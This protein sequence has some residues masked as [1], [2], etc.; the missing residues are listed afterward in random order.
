MAFFSSWLRADIYKETQTGM[1]FPEAIGS[2]KRGKVTPYEYEP[3]KKGVAIQYR[4]KD[5]E[6][7][8]YVRALGE[9]EVQK[10]SADFLKENLEAVKALEA[11]G[12]Y[13][14][15][16]FYDFSAEHERPGWKSGAFT[17]KSTN[18]F[19]MSFIYCKAASG[20]L[21]KIR[22]STGNPKNDLLHS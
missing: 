7:T 4:A 22:A 13:S 8:I 12:Q 2:Y 18:Y 16:Q 5:G 17:S 14:N 6:V 21:V 3:G 9:K 10:T 19:L 20:H 15:V 11:Q 1:E